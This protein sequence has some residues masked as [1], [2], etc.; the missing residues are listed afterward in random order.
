MAN[1]AF[2]YRRVGYVALNVTD[3]KRTVEFAT[4]TFGLDVHAYGPQGE[5]YL[6]AG[7]EHHSVVLYE[8]PRPAFVRG[9]F[10]LESE[11]DIEVAFKHFTDLGL[12]PR[13]LTEEDRAGTGLE[14]S[15]AF[16]VREPVNGVQ[17]E[18]YHRM[19][20]VSRPRTNHLTSFQ[21][22]AHVGIATPKVRESSEYLQ[23]KFGFMESDVIGEYMTCFMRP[24][25]V[26]D[27]HGFGY[28]TASGDEAEFNHLAFMVSSIDDIGRLY[29]RIEKSG[30]KRAFG[31]GRH[32]TSGSIHLYVND[33]DG[34][35]WEY[36]F[37]M[38]Q[39]PEVGAR[40]ARFM[41]DAPPDMDLW[42][43]VPT[44]Y[45]VNVGRVVTAD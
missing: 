5:C 9:G 2:R 23:A 30:V 6:R 31:L 35:A 15:A 28:L 29:N 42:G 33:P 12:G 22:L 27:H 4:D 39:F 36:T 11:N 43:A 14:L 10:Q 7:D 21:H 34:M 25:P 45:F 17:F 41:S 13:M 19:M 18:F 8:A 20:T 32:P 26:S 44:E 37:G 3:L 38:E 16:R 1:P 24:F 40:P